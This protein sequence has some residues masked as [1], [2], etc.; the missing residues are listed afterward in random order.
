M[1]EEDGIKVLRLKEGPAY[2]IQLTGTGEGTMAYTAGFLDETGVYTDF[3]SFDGVE[4]TART[5]MAT[6]GEVSDATR[7]EI[8]YDGDGRI[9]RA[10]EA[11]AGE[12]AHEVDNGVFADIAVGACFGLT[13]LGAG[14]AIALR[15]R[16]RRRRQAVSD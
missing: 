10:L 12:T 5:R 7:L 9:D 16:S 3:R 13:V 8:D 6:T 11:G 15:R 14:G 1:V 2:E 4:V